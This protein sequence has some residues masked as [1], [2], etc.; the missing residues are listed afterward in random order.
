M[1]KV[2]AGLAMV[3]GLAV[4]GL[5]Y[6]QAQPYQPSALGLCGPLENAHGP[7]DYRTA[8]REDR[9]LVEGAHF[10]P[11]VESL[12]QGNRGTLGS[13][14]DYTLRAF[15]NHPRALY[16]MTRLAERSRTNRPQGAHYPVE[17]YYDRAIR[18]QPNDAMVRGLY[19]AFLIEHGRPDEAR[20]QL[21]AAEEFGSADPQVVYNLGLA[22]FDLKEFDR[23]L[24]FA[25]RAYSMGIGFPGL[26]DKLKKAG[27]WR[28]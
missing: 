16:A 10:T 13:D 3:F 22:Y 1:P 21:K 4:H 26:R 6:S 25:R 20:S 28:E 12:R 23:S 17:C 7:F 8:S 15:H 18:F 24:A 5:A 14:I 2:V 27:K 9:Q 19:A 11:S